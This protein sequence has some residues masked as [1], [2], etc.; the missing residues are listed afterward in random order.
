MQ[1]IPFRNALA[2]KK[3]EVLIWHLKKKIIHSPACIF[4]DEGGN[5]QGHARV[6]SIDT[7]LCL[8]FSNRH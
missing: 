5:P 6:N 4:W 8:L 2:M 1:I 3:L 7:E